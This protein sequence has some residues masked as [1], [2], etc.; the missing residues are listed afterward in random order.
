M[1]LTVKVRVLIDKTQ[2]RSSSIDEL[3]EANGISILRDS[4]PG[5]QHNK[6][7]VV[8]GRTAF[9]GSYNYTKNATFR[10]RENLVSISNRSV[11]KKYKAEFENLWLAN[12]IRD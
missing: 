2:A 10:N 1:A 7:M 6:F 3:L 12:S 4:Q 11:V 8:D 5:S 9:T